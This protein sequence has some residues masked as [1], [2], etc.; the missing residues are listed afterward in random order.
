[1]SIKRDSFNGMNLDK[2]CKKQK[3]YWRNL[4]KYKFKETKIKLCL[5]LRS[6]ILF[7][8]NIFN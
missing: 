1:M 6:S 7:N 4:N 5:N 3:N 8:K 2:F